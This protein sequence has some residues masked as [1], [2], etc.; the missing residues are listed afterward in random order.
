MRLTVAIDFSSWPNL[1]DLYGEFS[2]RSRS[3]T[4]FS[5]GLVGM[6]PQR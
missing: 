3:A 2:E 6:V 1:P 4:G 5:Q